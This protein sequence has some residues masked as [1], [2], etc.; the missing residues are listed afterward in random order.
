MAGEVIWI[1]L[2][3]FCAAIIRTTFGF[4]DALFAMPL[5]TFVAGLRTATPLLGLVSLVMTIA[6]LKS[7]WRHVDVGSVRRLLAGSVVGIPAGVLLVKRIDEQVLHIVLGAL[8][9]TF[10]IYRLVGPRLPELVARR[11]ALP[12]GFASGC[13]GGAYNVGG[14]PIVL[15]GSMRR[16]SP[17]RFRATLQGY[18]LVTSVVI[19]GAHAFGGLWT[20]QVWRLFALSLPA[21]VIGLL[22]GGRVARGFSAATFERYLSVGLVALGVLL[23][24]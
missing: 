3:L 12:F 20:V 18:F 22:V 9:V 4:G 13:L 17:N 11:W 19:A 10:G 6:I 2:I 5:V 1:A 24:V 15:Y 16:W 21:V 23:F 7:A 14:P 8:L